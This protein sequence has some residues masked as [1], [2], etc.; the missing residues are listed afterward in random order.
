MSRIRLLLPPYRAARPVGDD[1]PPLGT[2]AI[3]PADS[4]EAI[5]GEIRGFLSRAPWCV[6]CLVATPTTAEPATLTAIRSLRGQVCFIPGPLSDARLIERVTEAVRSRPGPA[7]GYLADYVVRRTGRVDVRAE[8]A[9][10]LGRPSEAGLGSAIPERTLR[11]RLRRFGPLTS[12]CWRAVGALARIAATAE[13]MPIEAL[14][15]RAG[16]GVRTF[17]TWTSRYLEVSVREF[18]ERVGWEWVLEAVLRV[19]GLAVIP[20]PGPTL[21]VVA[22]VFLRRPTPVGVGAREGWVPLRAVR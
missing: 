1:L 13:P 7:G 12:H 16:V 5:E 15:W 18:R 22:P 2:V 10:L 14:A 20:E 8:L 4:A 3:A 19:S 17:R 11:D 21:P 9:G 6:P